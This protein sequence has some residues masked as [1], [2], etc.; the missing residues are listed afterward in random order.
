MTCIIIALT[1]LITY[2]FLQNSLRWIRTRSSIAW[3]PP[4]NISFIVT[5][6]SITE[7]LSLLC[8]YSDCPIRHS[9]GN[10]WNARGKRNILIKN[11]Q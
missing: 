6:S 1:L 9:R 10:E 3:M 8:L 11:K 4:W 7:S 2:H 5:M